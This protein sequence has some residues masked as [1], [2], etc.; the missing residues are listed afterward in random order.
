MAVELW[1]DDGDPWYLSPDIWVVPGGDPTGSPGIPVLNSP[2]FVWARVHNRGSNHVSNAT[3]KYYWG[4]PS[5]TV[6]VSTATLIGISYVSLA[7]NES[8]EVLCLTPWI[9][10]WVNN[11]HECL[12]AEAFAPADPL[13]QREPSDTFGVPNDRHA[14]QRNINVIYA[15]SRA[16]FPFIIGNVP[17]FGLEEVNLRVQQ[18]PLKQLAK[19]RKTLGMKLPTRDVNRI[20][21]FGLQP[22]RCGEEVP[23]IGKPTYSQHL[24]P[25]HQQGLVFVAN[26]SKTTPANSGAF[27]L[28]EQLVGKDVVGG[29][30]IIVLPSKKNRQKR[31]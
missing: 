6:T 31:R 17:R 8:K 12:I 15:S 13:P 23:G 30:G 1:I 29:I 7:P 18:V 5:T 21:E 10:V 28:I 24:K 9:P 16:I 4:N 19:L 27:F 14:A 26:L 2:A 20:K 11:G 25:G 22:Y 3:V